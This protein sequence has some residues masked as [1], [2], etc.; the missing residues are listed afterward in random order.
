M[1]NSADRQSVLVQ[2]QRFFDALTAGDAAVLDE[3]LAPDF[4]IVAI[5]DG[6]VAG[7][8]D[9]VG[10]VKSGRLAFPSIESFPAEAVVRFAGE[11]AIVVGRTA[12]TFTA[13]DGRA[14]TAG[15]RYTHVFQASPTGW[16][17]LSAQGTKIADQPVTT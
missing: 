14:F 10:L 2:D 15:S 16:Q 17:L 5:D 12:M 13:A 8:A 4:L 3:L 9:L 6:A 7:R 11:V 1:I